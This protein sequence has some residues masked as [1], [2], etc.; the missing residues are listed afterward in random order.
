[1]AAAGRQSRE[2][3]WQGGRVQQAVLIVIFIRVLVSSRS[4]SA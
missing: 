2:A 4:I 3:N 1:M